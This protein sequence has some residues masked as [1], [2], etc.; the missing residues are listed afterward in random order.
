MMWHHLL[1]LKSVN[2][3][4]FKFVIKD[5][6][7]LNSVLDSPP[8]ISKVVSKPVTNAVQLLTEA[9]ISHPHYLFTI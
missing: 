2:L 6:F 1:N 7:N 8:W 5:K 9:I 3:S 4:I